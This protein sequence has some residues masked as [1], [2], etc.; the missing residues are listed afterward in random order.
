MAKASMFV[1]LTAK[2][3]GRAEMIA[4]LD[5]MLPTVTTEGG[6]L[7][8][9]INTDDTDE[10]VVWMFEVYADP[11]A[12]TVHSSSDAMATLIGALGGLLGDGPLMV[13]TTPVSGKG[14]DH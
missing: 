11:D 1:K 5:K 14:F 9:S 10:D 2:P 8:Y 3:G 7:I 6:T 12:L 4:A 13:A